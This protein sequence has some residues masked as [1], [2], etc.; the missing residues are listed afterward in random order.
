MAK[1]MKRGLSGLGFSP[2]RHD[3]WSKTAA[4]GAVAQ[5]ERAKAALASG[6]CRRAFDSLRLANQQIGKVAAHLESG[7]TST[8][9]QG[10]LDPALSAVKAADTLFLRTCPLTK[11]VSLEQAKAEAPGKVVGIHERRQLE[12]LRKPRKPRKL[13]KRCAGGKF[14]PKKR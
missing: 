4:R 3:T 9:Q 10:L 8:S 7:E 5:A 6:D 1:R 14:C 12:G 2:E 11:V 13:P